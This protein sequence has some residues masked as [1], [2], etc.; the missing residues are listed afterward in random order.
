MVYDTIRYD[1]YLRSKAD[2]IVSLV[3]RTAQKQKIWKTKTKPISLDETV[4]AEVRGVN[5]RG[6]VTSNVTSAQQFKTLLILQLKCS[7]GPML[8]VIC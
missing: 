1:T 4:R 7:I 8:A 3:W 5:T 6:R 2:E